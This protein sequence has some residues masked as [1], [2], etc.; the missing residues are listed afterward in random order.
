[1]GRNLMQ[2]SVILEDGAFDILLYHYREIGVS[3]GAQY[4][5]DHIESCTNRIENTTRLR[6]W[7]RD[8]LAF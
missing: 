3:E 1:M 6:L 4:D 7:M 8:L 2:L 5:H